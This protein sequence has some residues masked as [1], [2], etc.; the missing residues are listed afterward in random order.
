MPR[1]VY[2]T[3]APTALRVLCE[4]QLGFLRDQGYEIIAVSNPD[5]D[6]D[7][8]SQ[9]DRIQVVGIPMQREIRPGA[10]LV[11]LFRLWRLMRQLRPDIVTTATSKASL[12]G[13]LAARMAGVPARVYQ[14]WG[15]R[16]QTSKGLKRKL[17]AC[18]EWL[19]TACAQRVFSV[20]HSLRA[21][22]LE[23]GFANGDKVIVLEH[24]SSN[25]VDAQ[26]FAPTAAVRE[27]ADRL[28]AAWHVPA[29]APIIGFVGRFVRDKGIT[30]LVDAFEKL[31]SARSD[32]WLLMVGDYEAGDPVPD[33]YVE[34]IASHP[35]IIRPG[36]IRDLA[37]YYAAM[38][39]LVSPTYREGFPNVVLEASAAGLPVVAFRVTGAV[40]AVV[41]GVT[42][43]LVDVR[44]ADSLAEALLKYLN[45]PDLCR[46]HGEA[47]R[48]RVLRDFRR[49]P[50]WSAMDSEFRRLLLPKQ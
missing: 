47:G 16:L 26:R 37:P 35:R 38:S 28:R 39:V 44:S 32:A 24:G 21:A 12:L 13:L 29:G 19:T 5:D 8:V 14:L 6:L 3:T 9:R 50:I 40:D 30:E 10:D 17:L 49:E 7:F 22:Y 33:S 46:R 43:T 36:F 27:S 48:E 11:S 45:D 41:E 2:V 1:L 23:A 31:L 25:G 18:A 15:L 42:G 4:G 34:R 20:S